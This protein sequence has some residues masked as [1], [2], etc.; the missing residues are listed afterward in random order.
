MRSEPHSGQRVGCS[1]AQKWPHLV[2]RSLPTF[3]MGPDIAESGMNR[4]IHQQPLSIG[5]SISRPKKYQ[6]E[7]PSRATIAYCAAMLGS[8]ARRRWSGVA[9]GSPNAKK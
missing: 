1:P 2:Q 6:T 7:K 4:K 8:P 3:Q 5:I 9:S